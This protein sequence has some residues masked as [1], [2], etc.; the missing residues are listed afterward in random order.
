MSSPTAAGPLARPCGDWTGRPRSRRTPGYL[1]SSTGLTR[2]LQG[3]LG[4]SA[5]HELVLAN[6]GSLWDNDKNAQHQF[7][8]RWPGS[9]DWADAARKSSGGR[10]LVLQ[11]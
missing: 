2:H 3:D 5:Y 9:F 10:G 6:A 4:Y 11:P 1:S 8:L 7:G